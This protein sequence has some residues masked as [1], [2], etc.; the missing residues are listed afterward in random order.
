MLHYLIYRIKPWG[1]IWM[2]AK[3]R[4]LLF[5]KKTMN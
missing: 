2:S 3:S 5:F 1:K 4:F